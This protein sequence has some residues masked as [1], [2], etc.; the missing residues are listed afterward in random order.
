MELIPRWLPEILILTAVGLAQFQLAR[1]LLEDERRRN[2]VRARI[3]IYGF[4]SLALLAVAAVC[5]TKSAR[6]SALFP[7]G[8]RA[9]SSAA[10]LL[11][12]MV[13]IGGV[14]ANLAWR[15]VLAPAFNPRRRT[16][17]N[18]ARTAVLAAPAAVVGFGVFVERRQFEVKEVEIP[19]P[20][21]PK[22]LD[23]LRLV[24]LSDIHRSAYLSQEELEHVIGMA[25][26][27]R[28]HVAL[29]TGDLITRGGDPLDACLD[30]LATLRSDAGT[31]G[32]LGNH[33]IY[34]KAERY[35]KVRGAALGMRFLRDEAAELRFGGAVL[36]FAGVD[37][38][39]QSHPYLRGAKRHIR[40]GAV[41]ILL[42]HNPDVFP[43]AAGQG[44]DLT[45]SGHTHGGQVSVEILHQH[46]NV[47]RFFTPYVYGLYRE[48]NSSVY[49]T[50]G[51]G[52]VGMPARIGAP[53][54]V[55]LIRLCAT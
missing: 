32:C 7:G 6:V 50:R 28:A 2:S 39:R 52:T 47:A 25:N 19:I 18:T 34:A 13:L 4:F 5:A 55:A 29:V 17:L 10:A 54:E 8:H 3:A 51:I 45:I 40:P 42:S 30:E 12:S 33:E 46:V 23:G 16:L 41:N 31:F 53:P 14:M 48:G 24:Q 22:D 15:H 36:N 37:Y 20:G 44:Y 38:Q 1:W 49:V 9:W 43:T 35:T 26:E 11:Y 21:L 27:C